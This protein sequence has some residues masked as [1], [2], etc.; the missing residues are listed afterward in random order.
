[1]LQIFGEFYTRP[2]PIVVD[3][4]YFCFLRVHAI[5]RINLSEKPE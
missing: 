2:G 5:H 4:G 1:M 3:S